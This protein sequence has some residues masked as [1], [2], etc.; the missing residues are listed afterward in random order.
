MPLLERAFA[1]W[2]ELEERAHAPLFRRTGGLM[3][4][5]ESGE[6]VPG[7][8]ASA[9]AHHLRHEVLSRDALAARYPQF[10]IEPPMTAN[11]PK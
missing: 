8:L 4:G 6:L 9:R 2:R 3:I 7:V 1:A 11:A 5:A 10:R